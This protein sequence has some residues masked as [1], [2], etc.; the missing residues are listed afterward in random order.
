ML[1]VRRI[2]QGRNGLEQDS[3]VEF[4]AYYNF[5]ARFTNPAS[6][7]GK[8]GVEEIV[9]FCR[10]NYLVPVPEVDSFK[11]LNGRLTERCRAYGGHTIYSTKDT[12]G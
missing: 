8:G 3:F 10:H 9:G 5:E 12:V 1:A 6:D 2:F 7:N 11:A 4:L